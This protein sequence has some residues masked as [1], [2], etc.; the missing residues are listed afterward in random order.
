MSKVYL[1]GGL[2]TPIGKTNGVFKCLPP[3]DLLA[4]LLKGLVFRYNLSLDKIEQI[5][6]GNSVGVGG[7]IARHAVLKAFNRFEIPAV[8]IDFQ[9]GSGLKTI[10]MAYGMMKGGLYDLVIAGGV[11]STSLEP[12][13]RL[14]PYDPKYNF[15]PRPLKRAPFSPR[16]MGDPDMLEGA[17][18]SCELLDVDRE[19]LDEIAYQSH[20][21]GIEAYQKEVFKNIINP[22]LV[23]QV[24]VDKDE[25]V[26]KKI[27]KRLISRMPPLVKEGGRV[28]AG[29]SCFTHDGAATVILVSEKMVNELNLKPQGEIIDFVTV[30]L[31]PHYSPLGAV[32]ATKELITRN[33]LLPKDIFYYEVNEAFAVKTYS[34]QKLLKIDPARINPHGG[35]LSYGH[36]YAA[37]GT[38]ILLHLLEELPA[39]K[40]GIATMGV[41]GGL[42]IAALIKKVN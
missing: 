23:E 18:F 7:N 9:C 13:K 21:R 33:G 39:D 19:E 11:D 41:A 8:S 27:S 26:R 28:T 16:E 22:V 29:N 6:I 40:L 31:D 1:L 20:L 42:G 36:P 25:N 30:G 35:A 24:L 17:E 37:S 10:E 3:E 34:L 14:S 5:I 38:I 32:R 4:N 12:E 2:R 15:Y